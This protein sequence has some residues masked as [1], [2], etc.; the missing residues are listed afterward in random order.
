MGQLRDRLAAKAYSVDQ[1]AGFLTEDWAKRTG[2]EAGI[3]VFV[4][5]VTV[6]L[7]RWPSVVHAAIAAMATNAS[8]SA[9][10]TV[11]SPSSSFQSCLNI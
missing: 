5:V 10:S 7:V 11:V 3:P 9:Y 6:W 2:L 4:A 1:A 8:N